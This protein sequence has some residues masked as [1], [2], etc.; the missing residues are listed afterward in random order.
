MQCPK[1]GSKV[2]EGSRC[3]LH[4]GTMMEQIIAA[5]PNGNVTG[6]MSVQQPSPGMTQQNNMNNQFMQQNTQQQQGYVQPIGVIQQP[7]GSGRDDKIKE[8]YKYYFGKSYDT[9]INSNFSV[10]TFFFGALWL[11]GYK[12]YSQAVSYFFTMLALEVASTIIVAFCAFLLG[13]LVTVISLIFLIVMIVIGVRYAKSFYSD[14]LMK[15]NNDI[16]NIM[17][18]T[19]NEEERIRMCKDAGKPIYPVLFLIALPWIIALGAIVMAVFGTVGTSSSIID[20]SRKDS[21]ADKAHEY[22]NLVRNGVLSESIVTVDGSKFE[23]KHAYY[24]LIDDSKTSKEFVDNEYDS[25]SSDNKG[26]VVLDYGNTS[27]SYYICLNT[28]VGSNYTVSEDGY[29]IYEANIK[30]S[31]VTKI[32]TCDVKKI[33]NMYRAKQLIYKDR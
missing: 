19:E 26:I 13:P 10:G 7:T 3:C 29:P 5:N 31:A 33:I 20:N 9:V 28:S 16:R 22:I 15:A 30:R 2:S 14:R 17:N 12:L 27:K 8:Y 24:M 18:V 4:C 23:D 32:E 6:G 11:L 25:T 21:A 1:C